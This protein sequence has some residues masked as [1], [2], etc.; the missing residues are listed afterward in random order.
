MK[1]RVVKKKKVAKRKVRR[2][3]IV[4]GGKE[5]LAKLGDLISTYGPL[6]GA[7]ALSLLT[8]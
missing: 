6:L 7:G 3:R 8:L 2:R 4:G 1:K 5:G